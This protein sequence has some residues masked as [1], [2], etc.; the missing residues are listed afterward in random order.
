MESSDIAEDTE[1]PQGS[2]QLRLTGQ[3]THTLQ[4]W[5]ADYASDVTAM[6][7]AATETEIQAAT[8]QSFTTST[9]WTAP[10]V[11]VQYKDANGNVSSVIS[12]TVDAIAYEPIQA[13]FAVDSTVCVGE[14]LSL[15]NQTTPFCEQCGW[16]WDFGNGTTSE[17]AEPQFDYVAM[18]SFS[19]YASPGMYTISLTVSNAISTSAVS[20]QVEALP[21]PSADF[22][23]IRSGAT[24]NVEAEATDAAGWTWDF[25]D[26][27]TA[28]GR[29]ATHTYTGTALLDTYPVQLTVEGNNGCSSAG[30]K[31]AGYDHGHPVGGYTLV[32]QAMVSARVHGQNDDQ[33][34][35]VFW[36][37]YLPLILRNR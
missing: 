19:G 15:T 37:V 12:D 28:T 34:L 2:V 9:E 27:I 17:E 29:I 10:A 24:I 20:H 33:C 8:W 1:P 11:F 31:Y 32:C 35:T 7:L 16:I 6:R 22:T 23:I 26:G 13:A 25:G 30:Y 36:P 4:L 18:S 14:G 5:A 3:P 21:A